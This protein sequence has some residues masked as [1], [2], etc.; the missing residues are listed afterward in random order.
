LVCNRGID[1]ARLRLLLPG[2]A[3]GKP[4]IAR[5]QNFPGRKRIFHFRHAS[6]TTGCGGRE[7]ALHRMGKEIVERATTLLLPNWPAGDLKFDA[8]LANLLPGSAQEVRLAEYQIRPDVRVGA[9]L[10]GAFLP[11]LYVEIRVTNAVDWQKRRRVVENCPT[12][13][14]N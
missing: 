3:C 5:N 13:L 6:L 1:R 9:A 12:C 7:S 4:L 10:D 11:A 14:M 2:P 8:T